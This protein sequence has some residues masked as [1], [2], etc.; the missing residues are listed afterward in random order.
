MRWPQFAPANCVVA[1]CVEWHCNGLEGERNRGNAQSYLVNGIRFDG[2]LAAD[3]LE[4]EPEEEEE[5]EDKL[6]KT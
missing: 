2:K 1:S 4:L 3:E 6:A 5:E